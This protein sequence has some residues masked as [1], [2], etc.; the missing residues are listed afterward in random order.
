MFE[1]H[2]LTGFPEW[3]I[4]LMITEVTLRSYLEKVADEA[5]KSI[6]IA[7]E[8]KS[9]QNRHSRAITPLFNPHWRVMQ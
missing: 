7:F 8:K 3:T 9:N 2:E 4:H 5:E 6:K 1:I